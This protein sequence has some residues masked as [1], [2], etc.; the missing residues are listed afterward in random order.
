M[1]TL[2][3]DTL[4]TTDSSF[5]IDVSALGAIN[6]LTVSVKTY[7]AVGDGVAN[8][9]TAFTDAHTALPASGGTII[10]PPG[11]YLINPT[12][13]TKSVVLRGEGTSASVLKSSISTGD[14]ITFKGAKSWAYDVGFDSISTKT[15]GAYIKFDASWYGGVENIYATKHYIG[16]DI[17]GSI[18][19]DVSSLHFIDGTS[20]TISTGG[21]YVR[22]GKTSYCGGVNID[23]VTSDINVPAN[24]PTNGIL[25]HYIDVATITNVLTIHCINGIQYAPAAGQFCALVK[26]DNCD[27][28]TGV[29]GIFVNP[30]AGSKVLRCTVGNTWVGANSSDGIDVNGVAG[31]VDGF[32]CT[33]LIAISNGGLG[34]N[35]H[36]A[37]AKNVT[38][39]HCQSAGNALSGLQLTAGANASWMGGTLGATDEAAG[40][41]LLGAAIELGCS[42]YV[43][44]AKM[45][46]N[47]SGVISNAAPTTFVTSDN[48]PY[49]REV[50]IS[51][52]TSGT[53]ALTTASGNVFYKRENKLC[54]FTAALTITTNGTGATNISFTLPF[55]SAGNAEV[56][57]G[58][59][60]VASGKALQGILS[61]SSNTVVLFNY[62]G[63]YPGATGETLVVSG[64]Y[65]TT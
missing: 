3:T 26:V 37:N 64:S 35:V 45:D 28:D 20:D 42:G 10:I 22:V 12:I 44:G 5:S 13:F 18:G 34:C 48:S 7:G 60:T 63:T 39:S 40:N 31:A 4:Q 58:R 53:G 41:T 25:L 65:E 8:D 61:A 23:K 59:G 1:S 2:R 27:F 51:S 19:V 14:L 17:D 6:D 55:T 16:I 9:T 21:A 38:F 33:G 56:F 52:V 57:A 50:F 46:G 32:H 49:L 11:T 36:G 24:K 62:D 30:V 47:G 15:A 54:T 29:K 43:R